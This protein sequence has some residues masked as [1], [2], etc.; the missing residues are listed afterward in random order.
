MKDLLILLAD[1]DDSTKRLVE[2]SLMAKINGRILRYSMREAGRAARKVGD[3]VEDALNDIA[4]SNLSDRW[5][6]ENAGKAPVTNWDL[7]ISTVCV[8]EWLVSHGYRPLPLIDSFKYVLEQ[9]GAKR[10][11]TNEEVES[12]AKIAGMS[13]DTIRKSRETAANREFERTRTVVK[14]AVSLVDAAYNEAATLMEGP[15]GFAMNGERNPTGTWE[16]PEE[17]RE[18]VVE[19]LES[20]KKGALRSARST[21]EALGSLALIRATEDFV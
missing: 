1:M 5:F 2:Y 3:D 17:L 20:A 21:E 14:E 13:T 12:M 15:E 7:L 18:I 4:A 11:L 19:A 6:S 8:R 16:P 9:A 10:S